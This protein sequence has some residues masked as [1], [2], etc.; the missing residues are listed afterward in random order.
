MQNPTPQ[1]KTGLTPDVFHPFQ[2]I[3]IVI[4]EDDKS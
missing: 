2:V 4:D 1:L 3:H